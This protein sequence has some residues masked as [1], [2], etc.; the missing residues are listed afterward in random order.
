MWR[1]SENA[2]W[3]D[4]PKR[5]LSDAP[6]VDGAA[7]RKAEGVELLDHIGE[8]DR[9]RAEEGLLAI[10]DAEG[11]IYFKHIDDLRPQDMDFRTDAEWVKVEWLKARVRLLKEGREGAPPIP[12]HLCF[13][14]LRKP[15]VRSSRRFAELAFHALR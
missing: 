7:M 1:A 6:G 8:Q 14:L 2:V 9:R 4:C 10:Q 13:E 3:R 5:C 12:D 15:L 11:G